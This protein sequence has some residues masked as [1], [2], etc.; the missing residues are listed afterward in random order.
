MRGYSW[1]DGGSVRCSFCWRR[2]HNITSCPEILKVFSTIQCDS[3]GNP[4]AFHELTRD[5]R[6][7]WVEMQAR[8]LRGKS[9]KPRAK[10][11]CS[12]CGGTGHRRPTCKSFLKFKKKT[13]KANIVWRKKFAALV[14]R[15]GLGIGAL[16]EIPKSYVYWS[17]EPGERLTCLVSGYDMA[18]LNV[19]ASWE[20]Q[21]EYHVSPMMILS[22]VGETKTIRW[23]F[24]KS[25]PFQGSMGPSGEDLW[26]INTRSNSHLTKIIAKSSWEPEE[27]WFH[28]SNEQL[29][30]LLSHVGRKNQG[31]L[32]KMGR[33]LNHW[34][35][36]GY[37]EPD[38]EEID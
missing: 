25:K 8:K 19:F 38:T 16:V 14:N 13:Y 12:F 6:K 10:A 5:Q 28:E 24:D 21:D 33:F 17:A 1:K 30:W 29:D 27:D 2:G 7:A 36:G 3:E 35:N 9:K 26:P 31:T 32:I 11:R 34:N 4:V 22:E 18:S 20:K 23:Q 15:E 37:D